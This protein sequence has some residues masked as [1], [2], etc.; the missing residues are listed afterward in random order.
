MAE[1]AKNLSIPAIPPDTTGGFTKNSMKV[2]IDRLRF[3]SARVRRLTNR[4]LGVR[5]E[6]SAKALN[7]FLL[8]KLLAGHAQVALHQMLQVR[9]AYTQPLRNSRYR[10]DMDGDVGLNQTDERIYLRMNIHLAKQAEAPFRAPN[11][12]QSFGR[13]AS[14][15]ESIWVTLL[16][17]LF[18]VDPIGWTEKQLG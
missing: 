3:I 12:T 7:Q 5:E 13:T 18:E 14:C 11:V 2:A 15:L 6:V 17:R 1:S 8:N 10:H 4:L 9:G 16:L